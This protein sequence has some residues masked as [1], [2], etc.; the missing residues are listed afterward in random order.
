MRTI[1]ILLIFLTLSVQMEAQK[2]SKKIKGDGNQTST[3]RNISDFDKIGV[4][5]TFDVELIKGN[6]G[7]VTINGDANL[8]EYIVTEVKK[9]KLHI[10]TEKGFQIKPTK[11]VKISVTFE[12]LNAVALAGS[13]NIHSSDLIKSNELKLS[14]AGSGDIDLKVDTGE[15]K[16]SIAGSGNINLSGTSDD[17]SASI[18]GSGSVK[19]YDLKATKASASIAGSG[20]VEVNAIEEIHASIAGSGNVLYSGNPTVQKSKSVGSGSIRKKG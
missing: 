19:G 16:S 15:L 5:G 12:S 1:T 11:K 2:S 17:F 18:A 3:T 9:G 7:S 8:M 20:N 10:K 13:S 6:E 4:S 14:M